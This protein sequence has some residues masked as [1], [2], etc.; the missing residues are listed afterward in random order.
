MLLIGS[1][2]L[3]ADLFAASVG[4]SVPNL[5]SLAGGAKL[6]ATSGK[7]L[8]IDFWASWCAPC[9]A[10]FGALNRLHAKYSDKGLL[11]IGFGV[12]DDAANFKAFV[13]KKT[14]SFVTLH[15]AYHKAA[16]TFNPPGMPSSYLVDRK[17]K[18]RFVH[19]GFKGAATEAE[20][21]KEIEQLLTEK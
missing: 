14:P 6:P 20:Y 12:D 15:D 19:K 16:E 13:A 5:T 9:D 8:L 10:S 3:P 21:V 11:I 17:G 7:V 18:I 2:C 4:D 1:A